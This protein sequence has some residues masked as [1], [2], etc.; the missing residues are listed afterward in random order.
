MNL[1]GDVDQKY[2][3]MNNVSGIGWNIFR[4]QISQGLR[5]P[6]WGQGHVYTKV[7]P[8]PP[9]FIGVTLSRG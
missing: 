4:F 6:F 7:H 1:L 3:H 8:A 9:G 2:C 5:S